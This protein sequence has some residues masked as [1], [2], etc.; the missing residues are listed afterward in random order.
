MTAPL[1]LDLSHTSHTRA[2][3]GIQRVTRSLH[4]ALGAGVVAVTHDP[5]RR[6]WRT[7]ER[8]EV[9]NLEA[10]SAAGKRGAAWPLGAKLRGR[11]GR[12]LGRGSHPTSRLSMLQPSGVI[13][14]EV[15]SPAV[16]RA[17]PELFAVSRG[18]RV[19]LFHDAIA[20]QLPEFTPA[21]TVARFPAYLV[22]LQAFDGIAAVSEDSRTALLDYWHWLGAKTVP[23]VQAISLG[24][25]RPAAS[26]PATPPKAKPGP[27]VLSV[28]SIEGRKNHLALLEAADQLWARGVT[29]TLHLIG[30]AQTQTG[31]AALA[32][33]RSLQAAGRPLRYDGP[34]T[35]AALAAA[36]AS[37]TLTVY[38]SLSEGFGLPVIESL[39]HGKPCLCS[40]GGALGESAHGGG[41]VMLPRVDAASLATALGHLLATPAQLAALA[42]EARGRRFKTWSDYAAELTGWMH[43]LRRKD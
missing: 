43:G 1:L 36:Y 21:K 10:E 33:I 4:R 12:F 9:A 17:L 15:F 41:C 18:P 13:I 30:L 7:L 6:A 19:A 8:W 38:P 31:A 37:C 35:D 32:R 34:V 24:I 27:T 23:P 26:P 20:L 16:A 42:A 3:T 25:D 40:A 22:E 28:G 5:H 29:F 39:V 11:A 14:P 2:R